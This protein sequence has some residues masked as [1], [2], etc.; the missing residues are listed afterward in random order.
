MPW[1]DENDLKLLKNAI[2]NSKSM[3]T[4]GF[5]ESDSYYNEVSQADDYISIFTPKNVL[6]IEK[7]SRTSLNDI[8]E[9]ICRLLSVM[10]VKQSNGTGYGSSG[11]DHSGSHLPEY[12]YV[13]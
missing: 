6:D 5:E 7:M 2:N 11:V 3:I 12:I 10:A 9:N 8:D 4:K 1:I 13:F